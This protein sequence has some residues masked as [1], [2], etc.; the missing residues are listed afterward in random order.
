MRTIVRKLRAKPEDQK[1]RISYFL[2]VVTMLVVLLIW[3]VSLGSRYGEKS[4]KLPVDNA[5]KEKKTQSPFSIIG[6]TFEEAYKS[7]KQ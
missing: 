5:E 6:D 4:V 2:T 3:S 1:R 7:A